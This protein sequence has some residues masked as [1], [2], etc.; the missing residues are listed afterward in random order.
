M[1]VCHSYL[2]TQQ[3]SNVLSENLFFPR[4][5]YWEAEYL[6]YQGHHSVGR[7][8]GTSPA[9]KSDEGRSVVAAYVGSKVGGTDGCFEVGLDDGQDGFRVL[10]V[11]FIVGAYVLPLSTARVRRPKTS[12]KINLKLFERSDVGCTVP[13]ESSWHPRT[14]I[15][16]TA[17][18]KESPT[19]PPST[20]L[21]SSGMYSHSPLL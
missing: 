17:S 16:L 18:M 9:S 19:M 5:N 13:Q 7:I 20:K 2:T 3:M 12:S 21:I 1:L 14:T 11:G 8:V 10:F 15:P 4:S 6:Q